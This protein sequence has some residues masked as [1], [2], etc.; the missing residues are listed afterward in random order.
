MLAS[1]RSVVGIGRR[2]LQRDG[3]AVPQRLRRRVRRRGPARRAAK[4]SRLVWPILA[5]AFSGS[6]T[7][8]SQVQRQGGDPVLQ[9]DRTHRADVDV[10]HPHPAVDVERQRV[11]HLH[12]DRHVVRA[13]ARAARHRHVGDAAPAA[14][15]SAPR[16]RPASQS[17]PV[18]RR[19]AARAYA[20]VIGPLLLQRA[21]AVPPAPALLPVRPPVP[22]QSA[23]S[24]SPG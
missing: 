18:R 8:G 22:A 6:L 15:T 14:T 7:P 9:L 23:P 16:P 20:R 12:V 4:P 21:A 1:V 24:G 13:R 5:V 19:D 17:A 11:R 10:G 3:V 2:V